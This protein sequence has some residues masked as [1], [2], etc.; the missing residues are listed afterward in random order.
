MFPITYVVGKIFDEVI[1]KA[2][3]DAGVTNAVVGIVGFVMTSFWG[4]LALATL[5]III[6]SVA[7]LYIEDFLKKK[8]QNVPKKLES[9][10]LVS[11]NGEH[12]PHMYRPHHVMYNIKKWHI[13]NP[14]CRTFFIEF[15]DSMNDYV[16]EVFSNSDELK[17]CEWDSTNRYL[18]VNFEVLPAHSWFLLTVTDGTATSRRRQGLQEVKSSK[19]TD[20]ELAVALLENLTGEEVGNE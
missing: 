4:A 16:I 5:F 12:E 10:I 11:A 13:T 20:Y 2:A 8:K 7:T 6:G 3:D 9:A 18:F 17:W 1:S 15:E 14:I 19:A